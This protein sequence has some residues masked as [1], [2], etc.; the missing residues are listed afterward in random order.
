MLP[1]ARLTKL[2]WGDGS[3]IHFSSQLL[4][5]LDF[6][7]LEERAHLLLVGSG[8]FGLESVVGCELDAASGFQ[9]V[10]GTCATLV[11]QPAVIPRKSRHTLF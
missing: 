9:D 10:I 7:V 8:G 2:V 3:V 1:S 4:V 6:E 5:V 11:I